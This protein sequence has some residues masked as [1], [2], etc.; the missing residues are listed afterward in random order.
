MYHSC[1]QIQ[2]CLLVLLLKKLNLKIHDIFHPHHATLYV[3][4]T[5]KQKP[6]LP[7]VKLSLKAVGVELGQLEFHYLLPAP[8]RL[9]CFLD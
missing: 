4:L 8:L 9:S 7:Q 5:N 2:V 3:I 1:T 6:L